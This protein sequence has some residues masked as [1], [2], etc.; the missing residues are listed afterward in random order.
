MQSRLT[1]CLAAPPVAI[2]SWRSETF[3]LLEKSDDFNSQRRA[4]I[5]AITDKI[6]QLT[7]PLAANNQKFQGDPARVKF[8][9]GIIA[10]AS[11]F[12]VALG[13][14]RANFQLLSEPAGCE[15]AHVTMDDVSQSTDII[16][17][18]DGTTSHPLEGRPIQAT[19]FPLL[20]KYG[21]ESG[22]GYD[23]ITILSR[24][25]VSV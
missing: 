19:V 18:A 9:E 24:A 20:M 21:N 6:E 4:G 22:E 16:T 3:F 13:K 11:D 7:Y 12:A 10:K 15:F 25:K 14:Q 2:N 23:Q 5:T 1:N 8:L 17:N